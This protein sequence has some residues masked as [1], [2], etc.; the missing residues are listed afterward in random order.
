MSL[1]MV[2]LAQQSDFFIS[3]NH[4]DQSWA[5]WMA[6]A[7]EQEGYRVV[8]Q[9]WD[10]R[11][12]S[13]FVLEMHQGLA[14]TDRVIA[15]VSPEFLASTFTAPEWAAAFATDPTG[16]KRNL[17]PVRVKECDVSGLLGQVVRID[18]VGLDQE[19][20]RRELLSG[21]QLGR[22]KPLTP[23]SFPGAV[24]ASDDNNDLVS[25]PQEA[26]SPSPSTAD[27]ALTWRLLETT[28]P[29]AWREKSRYGSSEHAALE[30][31]LVPVGPQR[32]E[33]RRLAALGNDLGRA[34]R[35]SGLVG[36]SEGIDLSTNDQRAIAQISNANKSVSGLAV[37]RNGQR[38]GW[39]SL[40][41]DNM[42]A[43]FDRDDLESR[44]AALLRLLIDLPISVAS[45]Y[46]VACGLTDYGMLTI[47]KASSLRGRTSASLAFSSRPDLRIDAEDALPSSAIQAHAQEAS[48]EIV[49]RI[50][51]RL[52]T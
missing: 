22:S 28:L 17:I 42:G 39:F 21:L 25:G 1:I 47:G 31:H 18:L 7:L 41:R 36:M 40:P 38:G 49:A 26:N 37:G 46:A 50:E 16:A 2:Q 43:I 29:V 19:A 51:A 8:V 9:A 4:A 13:N 6:W 12:G 23:P 24:T 27:P 48:E 15:I 35:D 11:P 45:E 5:E 10:F 3:Y 33:V 14:G 52:A 44:V 32:I 30:V 20:A 34:M